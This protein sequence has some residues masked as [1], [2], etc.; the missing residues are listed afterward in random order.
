M[1]IIHFDDPKYFRHR[2]HGVSLMRD[3]VFPDLKSFGGHF[4]RIPLHSSLLQKAY[5]DI[6]Y[7]KSSK[8]NVTVKSLFHVRRNMVYVRKPVKSNFP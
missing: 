3:S 1:K 8:S 2:F 7:E 6:L 4:S 5:A